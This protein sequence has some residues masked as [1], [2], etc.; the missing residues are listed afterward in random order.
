MEYAV[1]AVLALAVGLF[2]HGLGFARD[3]S[4]YPVIMIVI[5]T[6]YVLFAV[7]GGSQHALLLETLAAV[8]FAGAAIAGYRVSLW[9]VVIALA[10]HGVF[11]FTH[12]LFIANP[13][14]PTWWPAFCLAYDVVAAGCLGWLLLKHKVNTLTPR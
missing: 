4:L 7:I 9:W 8:V 3:R 10:A 13:G 14:V 11:D 1:G 12:G 6:Y 2:T 5:A